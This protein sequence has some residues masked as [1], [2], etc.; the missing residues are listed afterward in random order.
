MHQSVTISMTL[1]FDR[2]WSTGQ[3]ESGPT[4][5]HWASSQGALE[6][7]RLLLE[8]GADV[9]AKDNNSKTALRVAA[10]RSRDEVV[11]LLREHGDK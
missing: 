4:P 5:S 2:N 8:H 9:E 6:A 11:K 3:T 7:V 10:S 1:S